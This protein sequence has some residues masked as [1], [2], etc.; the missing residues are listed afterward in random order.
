MKIEGHDHEF[1]RFMVMDLGDA[2]YSRALRFACEYNCKTCVDELF[3]HFTFTQD[4]IRE[5]LKKSIYVFSHEKRQT[6][7]YLLNKVTMYDMAFP[8]LVQ[9][10]W[11]SKEILV[12]MSWI[13]KEILVQMSWISKEILVQM[14]WISKEILVLM[15]WNFQKS[16]VRMSRRYN[17]EIPVFEESRTLIP[18]FEESR[19]LVPVFEESR[20]LIPVLGRIVKHSL[21]TKDIWRDVFRLAKTRAKDIPRYL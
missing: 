1:V 19:T 11:I 7:I 18:V 17:Q 9:M 2:C 10:S 15:S 20:N 6:F 21:Y 13:S 12:Q 5:V 3:K 14:S 16:L 8:I 4:M